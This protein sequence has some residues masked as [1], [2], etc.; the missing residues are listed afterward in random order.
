MPETLEKD[1]GHLDQ[2]LNQFDLLP[3]R[4]ERDYYYSHPVTLRAVVGRSFHNDDVFSCL[5]CNA[6]HDFY[7]ENHLPRSNND[8]SEIYHHHGVAAIRT[9]E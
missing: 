3:S 7:W 4:K 1:P 8:L 2:D 5:G 9:S 6:S